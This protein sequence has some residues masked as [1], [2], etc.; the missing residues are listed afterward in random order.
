MTD[1]LK[2]R[3]REKLLRQLGEDGP[4]DAEHDDPRQISVETDLDALD[5]VT[6]DDPL[7][8]ELAE[9]YLVF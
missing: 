9:R 7:V 8:E 5:S 2:K 6:E 1:S 4:P 3:V